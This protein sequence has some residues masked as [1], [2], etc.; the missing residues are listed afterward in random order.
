MARLSRSTAGLSHWGSAL[1]VRISHAC[2][3][4]EMTVDI[5]A[6]A[7]RAVTARV[8][9]TKYSVCSSWPT[10]GV[11]SALKCGSRSCHGP[12]T[13]PCSVQRPAGWPDTGWRGPSAA[14]PG[15]ANGS[16]PIRCFTQS[17][18]PPCQSTN[19]LTL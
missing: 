3:S 9:G 18:A 13:P 6:S 12:G 17:V 15:N 4:G 7:R 19:A 5:S 11:N 2:T 16:S 10:D 1:I 14:L 8:R